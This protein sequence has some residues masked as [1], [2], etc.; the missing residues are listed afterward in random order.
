MNGSYNLITSLNASYN[1]S[2]MSGYYVDEDVFK[3]G[4]FLCSN[5]LG[6]LK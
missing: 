3:L 6:K 5:N 2:K 4:L 1:G